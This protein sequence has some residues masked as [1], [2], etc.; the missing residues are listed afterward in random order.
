MILEINGV[1]I[2]PFVDG[3]GIKWTKNDLDGP[4]AGRTLDGRMHRARVAAKTRLDI[5]CKPLP[6]GAAGI[7]LRAIA[8]E[9]VTVRY[10]DPMLGTVTRTMYAGTI[11]ATVA[12]VREDGSELWEG[13]AFS[14]IER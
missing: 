1:N 2:L 14:L 10:T 11:P 13:I 12:R 8:P 9:Y 4:Q 3:K 5:T 6:G 7:L